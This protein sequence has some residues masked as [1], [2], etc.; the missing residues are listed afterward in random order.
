MFHGDFDPQKPPEDVFYSSLWTIRQRAEKKGGSGEFQGNF[1][2]E[3]PYQLMRRYTKPGDVVLDC[4]SGSGTTIDVGKELKREVIATDIYPQRPDIS[5]ANAATLELDG[6]VDL[7]ILHPPYWKVVNYTSYSEDLSNCPTIESFLDGFEKVVANLTPYLPSGKFL[8]LVMADVY[9]KSELVLL[10]YECHQRI[11][12][13]GYRLKSDVVKNV[14]F[15]QGKGFGSGRGLWRYRALKGNFC[16]FD[17]EHV[18]TFEK[19]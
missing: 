10:P 6:V 19:I 7:I 12:S 3:I 15:T 18:M 11:R 2:P 9:E 13:L 4:F 1:I 16:T 8:S 14:G 5:R 17:H